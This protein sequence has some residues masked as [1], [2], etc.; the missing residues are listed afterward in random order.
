[1]AIMIPGKEAMEEFNSSEGEALLYDMLSELPDNYYVFHSA[2]WNEQIR[3][4]KYKSTGRLKQYIK[5]GEADFVVFCPQ[6]GLLFVE[7]KDGRIKYTRDRGWVQINRR[8]GSES[9]I[10]PL[11]QAQKSLFY[12]SKLIKAKYSEDNPYCK[13]VSAA[14]WFPSAD[15]SCVVGSLPERYHEEIV[16]WAGDMTNKQQV[17]HA[18]SRA[19][20]YAGL[21]VDNPTDEMTKAIVDLIAPEFGVFASVATTRAAKTAMFHKMTKEQ[22]YLLEY[23]DEQEEAA[24]HGFAGTGKTCLA[25]TKAKELA[26]D[27]ETLFLC[28]NSFLRDSLKEQNQ[29]ENL[30]INNLDSLYYQKTGKRIDYENSSEEERNDI[31]SEFLINWEENGITYKNII[32]DEGQDFYDEHLRLLHDIA[33]VKKGVFYVFYDRNQFVHGS[34]YP[35][36]LDEMEC[37]LVLSRNCRNTR[38]I[39]LT[40]T[41]PVGIQEEKIKTKYNPDSVNVI[42]PR[43]FLPENKEK[44]LDLLDDLINAYIKAKV[45]RDR[46][47]ILSVNGENHSIIKKEDYILS[48]AN[49]LSTSPAKGKIWFTTVRKFKGLEAEAIICIDV[50][51]D[52]FS[53]EKMRNAFYVGTSRAQ[54]FLDIVSLVPDQEKL[55]A[56]ATAISGTPVS[57]ALKARVSIA[58]ALK[59]KIEKDPEITLL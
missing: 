18:L 56:L 55:L 7:V 49:Q 58:N 52:T 20:D 27:E 34:E 38:E 12:F 57:N 51:E 10:D 36:W 50:D 29:K 45:P 24:I 8:D 35:V 33:K 25:M 6:R 30:T 46:I 22:E 9:I 14:V 59:V 16:F 19:Y 54:T 39:A 42:K 47:V 17:Q 31:L 53:N 28:F 15:R 1:M 26:E 32:I 40:S 41:R 23:L 13:N 21:N 2:R 43:L 3:L 48:S 11:A 4:E 5:W 37:R 44:M